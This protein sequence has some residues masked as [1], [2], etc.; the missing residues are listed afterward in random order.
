[1]FEQI[2]ALTEDHYNEISIFAKLGYKFKPDIESYQ[3]LAKANQLAL[4]TATFDDE[5]LGYVIYF[6]YPHPHCINIKCAN[7]DM[8]Y[9]KPKYRNHGIGKD[10]IS[11]AEKELKNLGI[12]FMI[13]AMTID[14]DF[15][16]LMD[17]LDYKLMDKL[18][19][20]E[21]K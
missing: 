6:C 1:M 14:Y 12:N 9:L 11:H 16:P 13:T 10:L 17:S 4:F 20:K 18:F 2:F 3:A 8:I 21:L 5:L 15:S 19:Y 7:M